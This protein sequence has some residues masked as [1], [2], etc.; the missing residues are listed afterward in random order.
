MAKRC[1]FKV[2]KVMLAMALFMGSSA[3]AQEETKLEITPSADLVSSYVW[4]GAYQTATA[5]QP[6]LT[7]SY[8]GFSV[9][10]WGSTDFAFQGKE[11]DFTIGYEAGGFSI[12]FTD[13]W[14]A[15]E[16]SSYGHYKASHYF[17]GSIGYSFGEAFPLSLS[18]NT[19]LGLDSDKNAEG[20]QQYSTY[21]SAGYDFNVKEVALTA[22]IGLA[23]WTGIYHKADTEGFALSVISL[24]ATKEIKISDSFV[25][26]VFAEAI[27]APNQD[28]VFLVFGISL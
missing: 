20:N 11:V 22:S 21:V 28:N 27:L 18:W 15:G 13:Y 9:G 25:L 6:G 23:P 14:W 4:R 26:P 7:L 16:G 2:Q 8:G 24:K 1:R 5:V 17:E 12:A 10:A 19:M 3:M